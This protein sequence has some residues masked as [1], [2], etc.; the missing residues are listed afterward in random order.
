M[1]IIEEPKGMKFGDRETFY[2]GQRIEIHPIHDLWMMGARYGV[3][4]RQKG[5]RVTVKM[6]VLGRN[7][8]FFAKNI[9]LV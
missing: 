9:K 1:P 6:D 3:V 2:A 5:D 8:V 7:K 4:V